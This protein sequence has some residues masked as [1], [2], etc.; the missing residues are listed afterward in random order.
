LRVEGALFVEEN[1]IAENIGFDFFWFCFGID[2]L[3]LADDL[4]NSVLAITAPN[5]FEARTIQAQSALGHE[6]DMLLVVF[7]QAAAGSEAGTGLKIWCHLV[8]CPRAGD[9]PWLAGAQA[10]VPALLGTNAAGG[11]HPGLT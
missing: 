5:D 10:G 8:L 3:Q 9:M 4:L 2:L 11:G 1:K 7:A 6:K